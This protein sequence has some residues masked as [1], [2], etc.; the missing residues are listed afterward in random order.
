MRLPVLAFSS[1]ALAVLVA[2][3]SPAPAGPALGFVEEFSAGTLAG[4]N[5]GAPLSNPGTGGAGGAGDGYL[6][7]TRLPVAGH[8]GAFNTGL[9]YA[10]DYV[11]AGVTRIAFRLDH[12][13]GTQPIEIHLAIGTGTNFWQSNAGFSP[14]VGSWAEFAVDLTDSTTFTRIIGIGGGFS[15]ALHTASK[16]LFRHDLPPF[17]G[18]QGLADEVAGSVGIDRIQFLSATPVEQRTWGGIKDLYR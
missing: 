15:A 17:T 3:A 18:G 2:A 13:A 8:L 1:A 7:I 16:L 9:A 11:T 12:L 6:L 5:S 10:G 4:F 14:P